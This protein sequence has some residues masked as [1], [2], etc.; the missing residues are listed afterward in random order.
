MD[1][2]EIFSLSRVLLNSL[3]LQDQALQLSQNSILCWK[4]HLRY[5]HLCWWLMWSIRLHLRMNRVFHM[6]F[7]YCEEHEY[8]LDQVLK[9]ENSPRLLFHIEDSW[10][11]NML[12]SL[13]L[14]RYFKIQALS[15]LNNHQLPHQRNLTFIWLNL[16]LRRWLGF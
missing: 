15:L 13:K 7:L 10:H 6:K 16:C 12:S 8:C 1:L 2:L 14:W 4:M 11:S 3:G 5:N 9:L